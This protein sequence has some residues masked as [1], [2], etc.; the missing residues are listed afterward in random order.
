MNS[1]LELCASP[2]TPGYG[3]IGGLLL[4]LGLEVSS[5]QYPRLIISVWRI[6][7]PCLSYFPSPG[8]MQR[9]PESFGTYLPPCICYSFDQ[10]LNRHFPQKESFWSK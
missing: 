9:N 6:L 4:A 5:S 2:P 8:G 3:G 10:G 7:W 1:S